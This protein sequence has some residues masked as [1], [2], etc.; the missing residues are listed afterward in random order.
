MIIRMHATA[1]KKAK[2]HFQ[3]AVDVG[4]I[5]DCLK[6]CCTG[7]WLTCNHICDYKMQIDLQNNQVESVIITVSIS[8]SEKGFPVSPWVL[9]IL[10]RGV[11]GGLQL[12][13]GPG[14]PVQTDIYQITVEQV[15]DE[16]KVQ[17]CLFVFFGTFSPWRPAPVAP[18]GP[19]RPGGPW[20]PW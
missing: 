1:L 11:L 2:I 4:L 6:H 20:L 15:G 5:H 8:L 7:G 18:S 14:R 19:G 16:A 12:P 9:S 10:H 3:F 13:L 17:I